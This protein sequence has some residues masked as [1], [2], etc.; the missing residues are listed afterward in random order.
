MR[1]VVFSHKPCW[2]SADS[3]SGYATDGG[4]PFQMRALSE[5]FDSTTLVLPCGEPVTRAG[6]I[7]L[8]GRN[9]SVAALTSV[10][11]AGL[12][13]KL[14]FGLWLLRNTPVLIREIVRADAVHAPIPGD[15]GTIGMVLALLLRKPLFV[16]HC[17]NWLKPATRAEHFWK[18]FM[19][20]FAGG[21]NVMLATGGAAEPPSAKSSEIKWI[22]STSLSESELEPAQP[23]ALSNASRAKLIIVCRQDRQKGTA[24]VIQSL[25]LILQTFPEVTLDI[26][27]DGPALPS[28]QQLTK[29]LNVGDRITFHGKV[30][31]EGVLA[32]LKQADLFCYPTQA[33]EGFPKVVLEALASGLPVITTRVSVLPE[34]IGAGG[35]VLLDDATPETLAEVT[36]NA[37][38]DSK[39]YKRMSERAIETARRF[40]LERWRDDVGAHLLSAWGSLSEGENSSSKIDPAK[41][42]ICFVVGTLGRGGA[43][44]QLIYML[45]A[46]KEAGARVRVL[47]LTRGEALESE[48]KALGIP[49]VWVG[50]SR[51]RP[52]RLFRIIQE[53]RREP[54]DV[55]HSSHFYTNLYAGVAAR[56]L[57]IKSVGAIRNDLSS[58]LHSNGRLAPA[59]MR[60][61]HRLIAN[62][63]LARKRAAALSVR[64]IDVLRNAVT[65]NGFRREATNDNQEMIRILCAG[66]LTE[67]KRVD[68]FL[69]ALRAL[70]D[71]HPELKF[72][73]VIAGGGSLRFELE[74]LADT[75]RLRPQHVE[76]VGEVADL[77]PI[78]LKSDVL[79]LTSDWEGCPN[80]LLEAMACGLP[81]VA[82]RVGGV[83]EIV[84][85]GENGFLVQPG[86]VDAIARYISTLAESRALRQKV[87]IA[88][89][90]IVSEKY[91]P[92]QLA[93]E[94]LKIYDRT[95]V[96]DRLP[97]TSMDS[98]TTAKAAVGAAAGRELV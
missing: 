32:L 2:T 71:T 44:R 33:S 8:D 54:A 21:R 11:G 7:A 22:F 14:V 88:G 57:G 98:A 74:Q 76:F 15:V 70:A 50:K 65:V 48:I 95:L 46:L 89:R 59:Q 77:K 86:D 16:R 45:R 27:G 56:I 23:R 72:K 37:L 39:S 10:W 12:T 36:V 26:V 80:V 92:A 96:R 34:L 19:E 24:T 53:L 29:A 31:H 1:L 67:Q 69:Y 78:Y 84:R 93:H 49:I 28:F 47:C 13:R 58:E 87:G 9:L 30:N 63:E 81:V 85:H 66:R 55:V 52:I 79:V 41:L 97:K 25:P 42:T 40:S 91:S 20:R 5:L 75:L 38:S 6:E 60:S 35:G 73:G 18:W 4:F 17:G 62:T 82:T 64:N 43:E 68:R 61:P 83:P 90:S 3:P 51:W 94:L